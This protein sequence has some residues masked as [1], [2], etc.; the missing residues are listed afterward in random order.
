MSPGFKSY[1][2]GK[3]MRISLLLFLLA[4]PGYSQQLV[5]DL[6]QD[7]VYY[8]T[9][10]QSFLPVEEQN[11]VNK[12]ISFKLADSEFDQFYLTL[13]VK[14]KSYLF[15]RTKLILTLFPGITSLKID[16]LKSA[17][18]DEQPFLT[19]YGEKLLPEVLVQVRTKP[20]TEMAIS[21]YQPIRFANDFSNF[22]YLIATFILAA[23]VLLKTQFPELTD[24]YLLLYRAVKLKTIDELIYKMNFLAYPSILFLV[25]ISLIG[26]FVIMSFMYHYPGELVIL[27]ITPG[28]IHFWQLLFG[29]AQISFLILLLIVLKYLWILL[30]SSVFAIKIASIHFASFLRLI[31]PLALSLLFLTFV[32]HTIIGIVPQILYWLILLVGILAMEVILYLKLTLATTHTLLYIIIYLCATEIIPIVLVLK[33][34]AG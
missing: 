8:N 14:E 1:L 32:Q 23:F 28:A 29:M 3:Q 30:L 16:S 9:E 24:Q 11:L 19:I 15:Y 12:A 17:I 20:V 13:S 6:R 2:V 22:F 18:G 33:F 25:F 21:N 34:I 27:E 4:L 31:L 5:Y 10:S 26:G 7:L